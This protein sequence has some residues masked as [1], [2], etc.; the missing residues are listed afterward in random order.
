M[1]PLRCASHAAV[2][3]RLAFLGG[4]TL[5]ATL[6]RRCDAAAAAA[7]TAECRFDSVR[8][9]RD[10]F[11][12]LVTSAPSKEERHGAARG[13]RCEENERDDGAQEPVVPRAADDARDALLRRQR[14]LRQ[15]APAHWLREWPC[16]V[17]TESPLC[18]ARET[19]VSHSKLVS[20]C[21]RHFIFV[22]F[23]GEQRACV[24]HAAAVD[25]EAARRLRN[26]PSA[27]GRFVPR[28][29]RDVRVFS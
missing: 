29:A 17:I 5:P 25:R 1:K 18:I 28:G 20:L 19:T 7:S 2:G 8:R 6:I 22:F 4:P 21:G 15:P 10:T 12:N 26:G 13:Q 16:R 3:W 27:P 24:T 14:S 9:F 11:V 23:F